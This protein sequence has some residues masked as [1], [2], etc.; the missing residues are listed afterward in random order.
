MNDDD[1]CLA[2]N[3]QQSENGDGSALVSPTKTLNRDV[4]PTGDDIESIGESRAD[5]EMGN[6]EDEQPLEAEILRVGMNPKKPTSREKQEY[7]D[8]GHAVYRSW[9]AACVEGRGVGGQHRLELT[10][11]EKGRL[12]T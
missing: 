12:R 1:H 5:V 11:K 3:C 2:K 9:R 7:E 4:A 10:R 8:S 6:V